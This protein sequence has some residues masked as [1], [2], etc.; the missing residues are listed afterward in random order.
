MNQLNKMIL[1]LK[2]FKKKI[3]HYKIRLKQCK[4][5]IK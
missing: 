2:L 3:Y 4:E 5:K 1:L